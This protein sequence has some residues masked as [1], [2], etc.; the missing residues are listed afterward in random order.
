[1]FAYQDLVEDD[2][3]SDSEEEQKIIIDPSTYKFETKCESKP[4]VRPIEVPQLDLD[5]ILCKQKKKKT[6]KPG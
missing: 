4:Q 6:Y 5:V 1:M 2:S 3:D